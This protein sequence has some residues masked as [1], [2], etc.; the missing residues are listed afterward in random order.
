MAIAGSTVML[1][2]PMTMSVNYNI[3]FSATRGPFTASSLVI[4]CSNYLYALGLNSAMLQIIDLNP[5]MPY[6]LANGNISMGGMGGTVY[7][8]SQQTIISGTMSN[9]GTD[10][11]IK[12]PVISNEAKAKFL[13]TNYNNF[14]VC[15]IRYQCKT[16]AQLGNPIIFPVEDVTGMKSEYRITLIDRKSMNQIQNIIWILDLDLTLYNNQGIVHTINPGEEIVIYFYIAEAVSRIKA[17]S[18]GDLED[19]HESSSDIGKGWLSLESPKPVEE[20]DV[21]PSIDEI[22][23]DYRFEEIEIELAQSEAELGDGE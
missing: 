21:E 23:N 1:V 2:D 5:P 15:G 9:T 11:I 18:D 10:N 13:Y 22:G 20:D 8:S 16:D 7:L 4:S 3:P 17:L 19:T 6:A 14:K 12:V